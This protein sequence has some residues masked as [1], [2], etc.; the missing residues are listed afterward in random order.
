VARWTGHSVSIGGETDI[1]FWPKPRITVRDVTIRRTM[2]DGKQRVLGHVGRLSAGFD[3]LEALRGDPQFRDFRLTDAEVF[4]VREADGQLDW[5]GSGL[6]S[7][8][9]R[10]VQA[11]GN[12]QMLDAGSDA[13]IGDVKI[14]GSI[15]D[16]TNRED[17]K[18]L[19]LEGIEGDLHWPSLSRGLRLEARARV[20]ERTLDLDIGTPQPLLLLS[21]QSAE[22]TASVK[23]DLF[24]G[25]F[26]GT[27]DLASQG[28]LSGE[29]SLS[30]T[31]VPG[32][33]R[34]AGL[35]TSMAAE[36]QTFSVQTRLISSGSAVRFEDLALVLNGVEAKGIL[37]LTRPEG[38]RPRL[39]GTLAIGTVDFSPLLRTVGPGMIDGEKEAQRL[40]SSL[41]LDVR[42]SAKRAT[43]GPFEMDEVALGIMSIGDQTRFDI[44]DSDFESG[45]L[46]GRIATI[47]Q[48]P[49]GAV[50]LRL[51]VHDADFTSI[52]KQLN[53][54]GPF[55]AA[56]GSMEISIDVAK[57][58]TAAAWRNAM[59]SVHFTCGPGTLA[60]IDLTAMRDLSTRRPYFALSEAAKGALEFQ[61]VDVTAELAD[62]SAEIREGRITTASET[63]VVTGVVPYVNNSLALSS[64]IHPLGEAPGAAT[65]FFIG[66]SWPDP[67]I[68]PLP[69]MPDQPKPLE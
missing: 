37:D 6:L 18:R 36:V 66:G 16:V 15:L 56:T 8:A 55:P 5:A 67:V 10:N 40:R 29:A 54:Q 49:Q 3:L 13:E 65:G 12:Q 69:R 43:L 68:W 59:G 60:G 1:R 20:H 28:F 31:D 35:D 30:T 41:D 4:V 22:A 9:V 57:P 63:I 23:S 33:F 27:A 39:T 7:H 48:G 24:T 38:N 25:S 53:F 2:E 17:G 47:R 44:L 42:L 26:T 14:R 45:R 19:R 32:F 21:G 11:S 61:S 51:M 52:A 34:W 50:A 64:T 58:L 62:G 46:T